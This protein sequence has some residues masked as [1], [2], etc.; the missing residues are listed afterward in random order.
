[1]EACVA[2]ALSRGGQTLWLWVW[3]QNPRAIRFYE[4]CGFTDVGSHPF[5]MGSEVQTDRVMARGIVRGRPM[6]DR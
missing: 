5:V 4:K 6:T 1:M 2:H 3:E